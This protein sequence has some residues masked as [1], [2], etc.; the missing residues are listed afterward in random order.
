[1]FL[2][3]IRD[4][5]AKYAMLREGDTVV[6]GLSGGAD[7]VALLHALKTL[8]LGLNLHAVYIDHGLRPFETPAEIEFCANL[9]KAIGVS[10][11]SEQISLPPKKI[12]NAQDTL[13]KLRYEILEKIAYECKA[14]RIAL[15]HNKD[16][17]AETVVLNFLRGS[18]LSGLGGIPPCRGNIIRPLIETT[19]EDIEKYLEEI[20]QEFVTDP[21][22]LT[23]KYTRN[24]VRLSLLPVLKT[25]NPNIVD[26]LSRNAGIIRDE[27]LY[28]ER[29][30]IKKTMTII[31]RKSQQRIELFLTPL[32]TIEKAI[33][34]R[35]LKTALS[36]VETLKGIG[37]GHIDDIITL[38]N[39]ASAGASIIL[40]KGIRAIK[41]Y[42]IL[43][44]TTEEK[45][46]RISNTYS[47]SIPGELIIKEA[48]VVIRAALT[49]IAQDAATKLSVVVD[50]DRLPLNTLT[51]RARLNGDFF[52]PLGFGRR[53]KVQDF[54]VDEKV[55]KDNRDRVPLVFSGD[56]LVWIAGMRGDERFK[57]T[58]ETKQF[59]KLE[60]L[61]MKM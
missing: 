41:G 22:N 48:G 12:A 27:N 8:G 45:P 3:K 11:C 6:A 14:A 28:M 55:P 36:S 53:K 33:L 39:N 42:S 15:G 58:A 29:L 1:M 2:D 4:T 52:Y 49:D 17:Q 44:I 32:Q 54:F 57:P 56:D 9:C 60:L 38:I 5:V 20:G 25:Y 34:R 46:E 59:V 43:T 50:G 24:K 30:T 23:Q 40:P 61:Q 16:D 21:S 51:V 47:L 26:T 18:A 19:R 13:R 31:S 7:S 10:F 35:V 37:A